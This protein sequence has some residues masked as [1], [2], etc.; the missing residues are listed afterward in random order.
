VVIVALTGLMWSAQG[1]MIW[2]IDS[3]DPWAILFWRC[4]GTVPALL[5][6]LAATGKG[7][8]LPR[9]RSVGWLGVVGGAGLVLAFGG[10]VVAMQ[11]TTIA[12]AVFLFSA[13]PFFTAIL[14][15]IV[16]RE[17]VRMATWAA[18]GLALF[19][20]YIMV[21]DGLD[22]G[23]LLGNLAAATSS[24]GFAIFTVTLRRGRLA[25]M[26][27]AVV[28]GA[29]MAMATAGALAFVMGP[30]P[31]LSLHDAA[32]AIFIGVVHVAFGMVLYTKGSTVIPAAELTLLSMLE[33]LFSPLWV[34]LFLG[35][36]ASAATFLGGAVLMAAVAF[37]GISGARA[38]MAA[39]A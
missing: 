28:I 36:T 22:A 39:R 3:H 11:A 7:Q 26:M 17:R 21:R 24:L 31:A 4:A 8:T 34:W 9:I 32:I 18:I 6:Y 38:A 13:S 14:G 10:S 15:W 37:N 12:N 19:G 27:P 25:D 5:I 29:A 23:A 33:V 16:L 30:G 1:L 2:L 35:E 20:M